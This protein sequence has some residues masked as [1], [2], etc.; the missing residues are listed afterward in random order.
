MG[1][2]GSC[3]GLR[4]YQGNRLFIGNGFFEDF[5]RRVPCAI[6]YLTEIPGMTFAAGKVAS[7]LINGKIV[8]G[9]RQMNGGN[10]PIRLVIFMF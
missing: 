8:F 5:L 9:T 2:P 10:K 7:R 6:L 3:S 4:L 1:M